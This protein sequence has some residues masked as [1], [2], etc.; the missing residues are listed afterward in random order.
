MST[1]SPSR[2]KELL[3]FFLILA[4]GAVF[5]VFATLLPARKVSEAKAWQETPCTITRSEVESRWERHDGQSKNMYF[6]RIEYKYS[7]GG[8]DYQ[9]SRHSFSETRSSSSSGSY[10]VA[11]KYP[12]GS[13]QVCYVNPDDPSESVLDRGY[14]TMVLIGLLGIPMMLFGLGGMVRAL[15]RKGV[16]SVETQGPVELRAQ[17][18]PLLRLAIGLTIFAVF[19]VVSVFLYTEGVM[20][21]AA[22]LGVVTALMALGVLHAFLALFNP[23]LTV[24]VSRL[25]VPAG[26]DFEIEWKFAG[27]TS[28]LRKF[29]MTLEGTEERRE[30]RNGKIHTHSSKFQTIDIAETEDALALAQGKV[31]CAVP[32]D[33]RPSGQHGDTKVM[34]KLCFH[35]DIPMWPDV[36]EEFEVR[37]APGTN[38]VGAAL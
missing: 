27:N 38:N 2:L 34:W 15:F 25:S 26:E 6:P 4:M 22:I 37:I 30:S 36:R 16:P 13:E 32:A 35:G 1:T 20:L 11:N 9:G 5:F 10:R 24:N 18:S 31:L 3:V 8:R 17:Q 29:K 14:P 33:T 21:F 23:R 19:G 12:V 28:R 7:Y